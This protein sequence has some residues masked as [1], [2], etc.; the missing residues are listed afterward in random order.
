[1]VLVIVLK[2]KLKTALKTFLVSLICGVIFVGVGYFYLENAEQPAG[3]EASS[4]PYYSS[5][6]DNSGVLF[7]IGGSKTFFYLDFEGEML[8]V[9][10]VDQKE[11]TDEIYG[12]SVDYTITSDYSIL[13]EITDIAGGIDMVVEGEMLRCTGVQ[14]VD[15]LTTSPDYLTLRREIIEKIIENLGK[16]GFQ[17]QDFLYIIENSD[18]N[19]TVP[20]CYFWDEYISLLCKNV[21]IIN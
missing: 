7:D 1:M 5:V 9:I 10:F 19:L 3:N 8:K 15:I 2:R 14:V 11:I 4:V 6:P 21:R 13:A 17:K 12:Y 20:D 16:N 18:T